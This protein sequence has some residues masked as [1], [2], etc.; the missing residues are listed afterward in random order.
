MVGNSRAVLRNF[1]EAGRHTCTAARACHVLLSVPLQLLQRHSMHAAPDTEACA[2]GPPPPHIVPCS[3]ASQPGCGRSSAQQQEAQGTQQ[4]Q[5]TCHS[6][7][8][9][10]ASQSTKAKASAP[11]SPMPYLPGR[12]VGCR[13]TPARRCLGGLGPGWP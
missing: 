5:L 2:A 11:I 3:G 13:M 9:L 12:L 1:D 6:C 10:A 7:M 4:A 8:P